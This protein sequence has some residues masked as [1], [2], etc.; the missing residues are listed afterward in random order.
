MGA[1]GFTSDS[2]YGEAKAFVPV[3]VCVE[4]RFMG[5]K[6]VGFDPFGRTRETTEILVLIGDKNAFGDRDVQPQTINYQCKHFLVG[7]P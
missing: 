1:N 7:D 3:E 2:V 4:I 5:S 6:P